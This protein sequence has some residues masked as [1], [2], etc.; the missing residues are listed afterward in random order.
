M[1]N[2]KEDNIKIKIKKIHPDAIIPKYAHD[3]DAGMDLFSVEDVV[4]KPRYRLAVRTGLEFEIPN[5]YEMQIRPRSG[6]ALK[7]GITVLNT[8]GTVDSGYRGE[9]KAILINLS[10][11]D[12][13][14][15]KGDKI[16]Q[17]IINKVER[18]QIEET[19]ELSETKR[20]K[21][22]FGSTGK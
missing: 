19:K 21:G 11:E 20:G 2:K 8:P 6:M 1:A 4:I 7:S 18:V 17:A 5:G 10:S 15:K 16:C 22:G 12:Y 13:S 14:I 3:G 9:I